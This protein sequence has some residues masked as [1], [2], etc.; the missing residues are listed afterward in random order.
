MPP[1]HCPP[2]RR[3]VWVCGRRVPDRVSSP[4]D[5]HRCEMENV[6]KLVP[7]EETQWTMDVRPR[8]RPA[9]E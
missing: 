6:K 8:R 3:R 2:A 5:R 4:H 1:R 7:D 9:A